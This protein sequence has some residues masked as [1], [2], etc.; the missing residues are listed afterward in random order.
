MNTGQTKADILTA[1]KSDLDSD[2][3]YA[4]FI[5][6]DEEKR[7]RILTAAYDEFLEKGYGEASTNAL[8]KKAG[9]S[10]GLLFRYF[11]SKEGLY[12]FLM[13]ESA[14]RIAHKALSALPSEQGDVFAIIKGIVQHKIA[15]C[16]TFPKETNFLIAAWNT[17]LPDSLREQRK[18]MTSI[19][20]NYFDIVCDLLDDSL[21]RVNLEKTVA[22][23]IIAWVCEKFS[24][25][26]LFGGIV[27]I[28]EESWNHIS[29]DLDK[30]MDALRCGLYK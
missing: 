26:V 22:A 5:K 10:K 16:L 9:I 11:G 14:R 30:Y 3:V 7:E 18:Q 19:S 24:D 13:I 6:L 17:N 21:L 1:L 23:E 12:K 28:N 8:T 29:E 27:G 4:H 25:K 15:V 2:D 20:N